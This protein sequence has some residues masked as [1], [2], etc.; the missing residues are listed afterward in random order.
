[1]CAQS[2]YTYRILHCRLTYSRQ[3]YIL[4]IIVSVLLKVILI[5][6]I[7]YFLQGPNNIFVLLNT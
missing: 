1:M 4:I 3:A 6:W 7:V 5:D 2:I